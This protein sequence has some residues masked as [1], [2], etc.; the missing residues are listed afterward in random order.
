MS[1]KYLLDTSIL[2][3]LLAGETT[4]KEKL[5]QADEVFIPSIVI[6]EL[7]Y[8]AWKSRRTRENLTRIDELVGESIVL[9]CGISDTRCTLQRD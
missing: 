7:Y 8:G 4:V 1:G 9:G 3:A 2:I 6:G 5:A